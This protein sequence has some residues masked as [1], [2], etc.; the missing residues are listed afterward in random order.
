MLSE[1]TFPLSSAFPTPRAPPGLSI[2]T[3]WE[4]GGSVNTT[5]VVGSNVPARCPVS[6]CSF[7]VSSF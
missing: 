3:I 7:A 6:R 4:L 1:S 5:A 2:Q